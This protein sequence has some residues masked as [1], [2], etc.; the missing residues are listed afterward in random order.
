MEFFIRG[1]R[2][3]H[4]LSAALPG[5]PLLLK[6]ASKEVRHT[7]LGLLVF[8]AVL[9]VMMFQALE[10]YFEALF[11][12]RLRFGDADGLDIAFGIL[13]LM[14]QVLHLLPVFTLRDLFLCFLTSLVMFGIERSLLLGLFHSWT[15]SGKYLRR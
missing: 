6:S 4:S 10:V 8:V 1:V 2:L 14:Y 3:K 15:A 12:H 9:T 13:V 7:V 5:I 11:I